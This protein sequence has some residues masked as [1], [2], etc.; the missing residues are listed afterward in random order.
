MHYRLS[1]ALGAVKTSSRFAVNIVTLVYNSVKTRRSPALIQLERTGGHFI[2]RLY[3]SHPHLPTRFLLGIRQVFM[4]RAVAFLCPF[5]I[6]TG[7]A[8]VKNPTGINL[9]VY[10]NSQNGFL[11]TTSC[12]FTALCSPAES[13]SPPMPCLSPDK[14]ANPVRLQPPFSGR[15]KW[16]VRSSPARS[17]PG[18]H[19]L[20]LLPVAPGW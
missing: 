2:P 1:A 5:L 3:R 14:C 13:P 18:D 17:T 12:K 11:S 9:F 16:R 6:A 10:P 8:G 15:R 20:R 19:S 4:E 7:N